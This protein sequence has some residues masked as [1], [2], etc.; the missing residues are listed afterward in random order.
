MDR[1]SLDR[2][3]LEAVGLRED[4]ERNVRETLPVLADPGEG[5]SQEAARMLEAEGFLLAF[6][7]CRG[8]NDLDRA[9]PMRLRR[10]NVGR[11]ANAA[12]PQ[13]RLIL[14]PRVFDSLCPLRSMS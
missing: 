3:R 14:A 11:S 8:A 5:F 7:T 10:M 13:A 12:M 4:L 6:T 9:D 2:A 1:I